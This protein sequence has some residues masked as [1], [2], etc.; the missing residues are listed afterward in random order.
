[1]L[2]LP[3]L[4]P[5]LSAQRDISIAQLGLAFSVFGIV[6]LCVQTPMG[7]V[8]DRI[9]A[10]RTLIAGLTLGSLC[11]LSLSISS[12]YTWLITAMALA[13]VANAV[14]HPAD[15]AL[16]SRNI[17]EEQ[18]G[19]AFS[20]HTFYGFLG[21]TM[22]P[23]VLLTVA[24]FSGINSAFI[25]SGLIG[26]I[27]I[28]FLLSESDRPAR[29]QHANQN[30][31][32]IDKPRVSLFTLPIMAL[33][34]LFL[35]LNMGTSSIKNFLVTAFAMGDALP[36]T[37]G[38]MILMVFLST[39]AF[40]ILAG[41]VLA[42]K[43]HRHGLVVT[44][45][46]TLTAMLISIAALYP[47]PVPILIPLFTIAGFMSG[48]VVPS[49]DMLVR[50]ASPAGAEGRVFGI[51]FTGF[52]IGGAAG[53]M[54]SGWLL[55]LAYPKAIFWSVVIFMLIAALITLWQGSR[56]TKQRTIIQF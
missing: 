14:Y 43:T 33:L 45:A 29:V 51:V 50:A 15:Y 41:G 37:Q 52:S 55:Y 40:G 49:R 42:D 53:P 46:L 26:L 54:L 12:S 11:F 3:T 24:A 21:T 1:M 8:V 5:L 7:F 28:P 56:R 48:I 30:K 25:I 17:D 18:M 10:R 16:L 9:G 4:M 2:V 23:S 13:G 27:P 31:K 20:I 22:A 44:A 34:V 6:S 47:L 32:L 19:R 35:L 38:N 36:L 39:S